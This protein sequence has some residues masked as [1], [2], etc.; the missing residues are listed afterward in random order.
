MIVF[1]YGLGDTDTTTDKAYWRFITLF[2]IV[3][4]IIQFLMFGLII[5]SPRYYLV[6]KGDVDRVMLKFSYLSQYLGPSQLR[7]NLYRCVW[8]I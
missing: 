8:A 3:T 5:E 6:A 7:E 2:P 1:G 4:N